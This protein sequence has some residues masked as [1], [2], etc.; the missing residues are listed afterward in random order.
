MRKTVLEET[1][2]AVPP[3]AV[4]ALTLFGIGLQDWVYL[5]TMLYIGIQV[6]WFVWSKIM[7]KDRDD[8]DV[9]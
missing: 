6:G 3:V 9:R 2:K 4:S 8:D 7:R 5:L 1:A